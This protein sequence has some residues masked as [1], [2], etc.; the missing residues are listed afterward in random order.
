MLNAKKGSYYLLTVINVG[1]VVSNVSSKFK[2]LDRYVYAYFSY[3]KM[4]TESML[5]HVC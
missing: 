1:E 5:C 2:A 3:L 4:R